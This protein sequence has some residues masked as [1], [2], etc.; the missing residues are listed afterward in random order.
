MINIYIN[1][2]IIYYDTALIR[3]TSYNIFFLFLVPRTS[4]T[5]HPVYKIRAAFITREI[6]QNSPFPWR[7]N[8]PVP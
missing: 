1:Y 5:G 7:N 3:F 6:K 8:S 4:L 2:L